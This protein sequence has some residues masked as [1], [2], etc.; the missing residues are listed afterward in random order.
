MRAYRVSLDI[1]ALVEPQMYD[2]RY[3]IMGAIRNRDS[4]AA[5]NAGKEQVELSLEDHHRMI[6]YLSL[7]D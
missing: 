5:F 6:E 3:G 1:L 7:F 2:V 4:K